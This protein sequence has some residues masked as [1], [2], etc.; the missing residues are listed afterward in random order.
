MKLEVL[1]LIVLWDQGKK[2]ISLTDFNAFFY[3][4]EPRNLGVIGIIFTDQ[5]W[6][7]LEKLNDSRL[8]NW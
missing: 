1:E 4:L 6:K 3:N 7:M 5:E 2:K 8:N